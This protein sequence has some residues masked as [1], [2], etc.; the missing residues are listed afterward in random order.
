MLEK[1]LLPCISF[2][3]SLFNSFFSFVWLIESLM[4]QACNWASSMFQAECWI[5]GYKN[6]NS[7][8]SQNVNLLIVVT[9]LFIFIFLAVQLAGSQFPD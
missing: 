7:L 5:L 9:D 8:D 4:Q 1:N 2:I 3:H 6:K